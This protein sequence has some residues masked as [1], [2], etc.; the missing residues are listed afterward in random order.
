MR[1]P[2]STE[3]IQPRQL[4]NENTSHP[5][6]KGHTW[7]YCH[8][9][10]TTLCLHLEWYHLEGYVDKCKMMKW[11]IAIAS[12]CENMPDKDPETVSPMTQNV[13][14]SVS[15]LTHH[16]TQWIVANDQVCGFMACLTHIS[17]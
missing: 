17:I 14:F 7:R 6:L 15:G 9:S 11:T 3:V 5:S 12:L 1:L 2:L 10:N 8:S 16:I 4:Y 13:K